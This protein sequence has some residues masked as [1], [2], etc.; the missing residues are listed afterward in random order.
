MYCATQGYGE[1]IKPRWMNKI[2][3]WQEP[4]GC[5]ADDRQPFVKL[6]GYVKHIPTEDKKREV[7]VVWTRS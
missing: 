3:S 6:T 2:V 4:K 1:F 5:F 7:C